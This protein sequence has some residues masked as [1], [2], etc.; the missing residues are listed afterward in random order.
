LPVLLVIY[1]VIALAVYA[2]QSRH[3][4][5]WRAFMESLLHPIPVFGSARRCLALG[6]LAAALEAMLG[7]G[8]TIIEAWQMAAA[9]C[10]SPAL[11]RTVA[12]WK[13]EML[14]GRTP[15]EMVSASPSFPELFASQYA[16]GEVSGKL[17]EALHTLRGY[18]LAEGSHKISIVAEWVPRI[19]Y[20][21]VAFAVACVILNFYLG[22]IQ[23]LQNVI[24]Q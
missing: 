23:Q 4:D 6:R 18:Y 2:A 13:P 20:L 3:G 24:G 5:T 14:A 7:A 9:A 12:A 8:V 10:G 19:V 11:A 15:S 21:I 16:T 17:E 22:R 1:G